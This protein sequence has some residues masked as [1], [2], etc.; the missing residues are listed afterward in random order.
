M[1]AKT[2][3]FFSI[4]FFLLSSSS[5]MGGFSG[6]IYGKVTPGNVQT[7]LTTNGDVGALTLSDG[8]FYMPHHGGD[9][10]L[11]ADAPGFR[12]FSTPITVIELE[13]LYIE[14]TLQL[15][16]TA[17]AGAGGAI[18]PSGAVAVDYGGWRTF[19]ITPKSGR[20]AADVEV[21]GASV[22]AVASYTFEN[23]TSDHTIKASFEPD[24]TVPSDV[25]PDIKANGSDGPLVVSASDTV[26]ISVT[27]A[28]GDHVGLNA[29]WW[30]AR[31]RLDPGFEWF[32]YTHPDQWEPRIAR[33]IELP[34]APLDNA[35]LPLLNLPV[36]DYIFYFAVDD[37]ADGQPDATWL[38]FV[39]L[40]VRD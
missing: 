18:S 3:S 24:A 22:G 27:L 33:T 32:F 25:I 17:T 29:D 28:P 21:D 19:T 15:T 1:K 7:I 8:S 14:I 5:A 10:I 34:L 16:I 6:L 11:Y 38:D 23:A 26:L 40:H 2:A 31:L 20:M 30:I 4:I 37:N 13:T 39:E 9:F 36:G 35:A 12:Q